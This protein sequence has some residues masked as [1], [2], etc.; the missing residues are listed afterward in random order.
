[1]KINS[2][3]RE[4]TLKQG[5]FGLQSESQ[6]FREKNRGANLNEHR[7]YS[8]NYGGSFTGG[9]DKAAANAIKKGGILTSNWFNKFLLYS[10]E[11]NI[12]TS[13]LVAL[14]L[15]GVARPATIMVLPG[16]KDKEDKIYA[17]GHSMASAIMGFV[18]SSIIT[19]PLDDSIKKVFGNPKLYGSKK[20]QEMERQCVELEKTANIRDK[21]GK[22]VNREARELL[23]AL[24]QKRAAMETLAKNIPDWIIAVPRATL[25]IALIPPILKY[26]F[27]VEKKKKAVPVQ[28]PQI[29]NENNSQA[30][31]MDFVDKPVFQSFKGGVR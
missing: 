1:M 2:V 30:T 17:S 26:V 12:S 3:N 27:G 16:D 6:N 20:L 22:I 4:M 25:T 7:G 23:K 13:A 8:A 28:E 31:K 11:H 24:K 15:A 19:S 14:A 5:N 29:M 21:A 10:K 9:P 18:V